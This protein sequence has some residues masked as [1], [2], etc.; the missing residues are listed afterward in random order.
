MNPIKEQWNKVI[1]EKLKEGVTVEDLAHT[2]PSG[3]VMEPNVLKSDIDGYN[4]AI[5]IHTS[6]TNMA[7]IQGSTSADK[8]KL[9]LQAL[10]EGANGLHIE[11]SHR[12]AVS[13]ILKGVLT[14]YLDVR[15]D[16]S[17]LSVEE[18]NIQKSLLSEE[19]FPNVRWIH[20][21]ENVLPYNISKE[22]RVESIQSMIKKIDASKPADIV[23]TL[24]KNLL[25]EIASLRAIRA[26]VDAKQN[27]PLQI[28]ARYEVEGT[29]TLG[30]YDLIEKTYKV[31]SG[32]LGGAD[33]IL[34]PYHGDE[35]SRL[36]LN[37]HNVLDLESGMKNVLDPLKGSYYIEKLTGEII[38]QVN[39]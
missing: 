6:W 7:S 16:A 4:H 39:A 37:I 33:A 13:D 24:S 31:L 17:A 25:F 3:I 8:N 1:A 29:N 35:N 14:E 22:K 12:D 32:I 21:E 20:H 28:I 2:Y 9:A 23:V 38:R 15:I 26:L 11:L 34:T 10:Q 30:D 5:P 27:A 36:T 19:A 18:L